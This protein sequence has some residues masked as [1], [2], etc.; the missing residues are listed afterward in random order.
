MNAVKSTTSS[1]E[2]STRARMDRYMA[3]W[4]DTVMGKELS[5]LRKLHRRIFYATLLILVFCTIG[6]S[7]TDSMLYES[8]AHASMNLVNGSQLFRVDLFQSLYLTR[9]LMLAYATGDTAIALSLQSR[10][11]NI[12]REFS[13]AHLRNFQQA[14]AAVVQFYN[15]QRWQIYSPLGMLFQP[16]R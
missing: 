15:L 16:R 3:S 11:N 13:V 9:S 12:S 2:G 10:L 14:P 5:D 8:S 4:K 7:L 1:S 6:F